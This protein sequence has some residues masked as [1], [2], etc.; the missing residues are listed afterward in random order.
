[1]QL[2]RIHEA[3]REE[4]IS[5]GPLTDPRTGIRLRQNRGVAR[6]AR[7]VRRVEAANRDANTLPERRRAYRLQFLDL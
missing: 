1:M 7:T 4:I 6:R 3:M 5:Q 2:S